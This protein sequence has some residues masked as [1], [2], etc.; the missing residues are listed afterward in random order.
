MAD[1]SDWGDF[2]TGLGN[3][4]ATGWKAANPPQ[5]VLAVPTPQNA[6]APLLPA[7]TTKVVQYVAIAGAVLLLG[8][9]AFWLVKKL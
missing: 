7:T 1:L 3:S 2:L 8:F 5:P 9:G 4:F 6:A